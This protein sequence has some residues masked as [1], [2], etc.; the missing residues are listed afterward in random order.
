MHA[1]ATAALLAAAAHTGAPIPAAPVTVGPGTWI[2]LAGTIVTTVGAVI[3]ML[4][5]ARSWLNSA[6]RASDGRSL[7][8][9]VEG[10]ST[11]LATLADKVDQLADDV[12][13]LRGHQTGLAD[14]VTRVETRID[15]LLDPRQR[16][17]R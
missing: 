13:E 17:R 9:V 5:K 15:D 2:T 7:A 16:R 8:Q 10:N 4:V 3:T 11:V 1:I 6:V 12:H 14:R